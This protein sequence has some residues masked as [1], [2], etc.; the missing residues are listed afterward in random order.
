M[1]IDFDLKLFLA[2]DLLEQF[3]RQSSRLVLVVPRNILSEN[4]FKECLPHPMHHVLAGHQITSHL[5]RCG[6]EQCNA[7]VDGVEDLWHDVVAEL[8]EGV[9]RAVEDRPARVVVD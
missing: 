9:V 7:H 6:N 1:D 2:P 8:V 3:C 4:R 5:D